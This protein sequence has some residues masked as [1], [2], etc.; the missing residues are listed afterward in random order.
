LNRNKLSF[1]LKFYDILLFIMPRRKLKG[2]GKFKEFLG[3]ANNFLKKSQILSKLGNAYSKYGG[4][5]GLPYAQ[6]V[7]MA[8]NAAST[9]GYGRRR[10]RR[11][12]GLRV[13][14]GSVR[15][16]LGLSLAGGSRRPHMVA[17]RPMVW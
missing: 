8:S 3:K 6:Q 4:M 13:A 12:T 2:K 14:G 15:R 11:G 16:G 10:M 5:I 7:G 1:L 17:R 9:A